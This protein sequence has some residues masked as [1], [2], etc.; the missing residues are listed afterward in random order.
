[1]PEQ[2][3]C[4]SPMSIH[5][6][7]RKPICGWHLCLTAVERESARWARTSETRRLCLILKNV[8]SLIHQSVITLNRV[9]HLM[10]LN[11]ADH[12]WN[13]VFLGLSHN[14]N[15]WA[16]LTNLW[17]EGWIK[18]KLSEKKP[19]ISFLTFY[20]TRHFYKDSGHCFAPV[21]IFWNIPKW[22]QIG[23]NVSLFKGDGVVHFKF[24]FFIYLVFLS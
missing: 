9:Q 14:T 23:R 15:S 18:S 24:Y 20:Q 11:A 21:F 6:L 4:N 5:T 22:I 12:L 19:G 7:T 10:A 16:S 1:M 3:V 8:A 17:W 2:R 13:V